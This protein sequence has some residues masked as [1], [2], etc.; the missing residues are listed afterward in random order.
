MMKSD[1]SLNNRIP[2]YTVRTIPVHGSYSSKLQHV[3]ENPNGRR[4]TDGGKYCAVV[5]MASRKMMMLT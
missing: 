3:E 5:K 1:A 4:E 2:E